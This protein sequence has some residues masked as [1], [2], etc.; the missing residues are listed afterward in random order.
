MPFSFRDYLDL[1]SPH[2]DDGS[3]P[4]RYQEYKGQN[5]VSASTLKS[6]MTRLFTGMTKLHLIHETLYGVKCHKL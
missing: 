2:N 6:L 4:H 3:L 5:E 1:S